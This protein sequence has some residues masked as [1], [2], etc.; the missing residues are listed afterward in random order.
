M[1][2]AFVEGFRHSGKVTLALTAAFVTLALALGERFVVND[3]LALVPERYLLRTPNDDDV[4]AARTL[5]E[6][7]R[8]RRE[9]SVILVFGSSSTKES[10]FSND[11]VTEALRREL[12]GAP[13][14]RK[15]ATGDQSL[16]DTLYFVDALPPGRGWVTIGLSP[17]SL[18]QAVESHGELDRGTALV[19]YS[20]ALAHEWRED[21]WRKWRYRWRLPLVLRHFRAVLGNLPERPSGETLA[22]FL[23]TFRWP[24]VAYSDHLYDKLPRLTPEQLAGYDRKVLDTYPARFDRNRAWNARVLSRI[25]ALAREKGYRVLFFD[26]PIS[27]RSM[28]RHGRLLADYH[29]TIDEIA[30]ALHVPRWSF[31]RELPLKDDLY[32]DFHHLLAEGRAIYQARWVSMLAQQLREAR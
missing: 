29:R 1:R 26:A 3:L 9:E 2:R 31:V 14:I 13:A 23:S 17:G 22:S 7:R 20:S 18:L 6:L 21:D 30:R 16:E 25:V 5:F 4:R 12:P 28:E 10:L 32:F 19:P 11:K 27:P 24:D 15:L 8:R